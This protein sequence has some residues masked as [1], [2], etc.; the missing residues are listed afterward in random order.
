MSELPTRQ[1]H[2]D[3][4]MPSLPF[5]LGKNFDKKTF[6]KNL[7]T[8]H[9]NSITLTARCHHGFLYFSSSLPAVHPQLKGDFLMSMVDACH[10]MGIKCPLYISA[11]WDAFQAYRHPEWLER[12]KDGSFYGFENFGQP[13]PGWKTLCFSSPYTDYLLNITEEV[14]KHFSG[15]LDGLFFDI[16]T[17]DPCYCNNCLKKMKKNNFNPLDSLSV[18]EFAKQKTYEIKEK[19][20]NL[21]HSIQPDCP[22]FF[23]EGDISP[24]MK[25]ALPFYSHIEIESLASGEWGYNYFPVAVRYAKKLGKDYL[26]MTAKFHQNWGDFGSYKNEAALAYECFLA[27]AHGAK[28]SIGDQMYPD[29]TL[30]TRTY[31]QISTIYSKIERLEAITSQITP[32]SQIAICYPDEEIGK[33]IPDALAGAT[34]LLNE[35]HFQF[36]IIDSQ[37]DFTPYELIILPDKLTLNSSLQKN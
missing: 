16:L 35:L 12:K 24:K 4:H 9:V 7:L 13:E 6:Q 2:L 18:E 17:Q 1:I 29:G 19:L 8:A 25:K 23:N 3:F 31:E 34:T 36:D 28:C 33:R 37:M 21:I 22:I 26:G 11:G 15:K 32:K 20:T 30:N 27:N 14:M 10:E 5:T